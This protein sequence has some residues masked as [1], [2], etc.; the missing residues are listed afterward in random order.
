MR[1]RGLDLNLLVVLDALLAERNLSAA[2]RRINLSQP[3]MSAAVA[4]L[5]DFFGDELFS[6]NGRERILTS[7]AAALGPAVRDALLHIQRTIIS[8]D[9]FDPA[10]SDRRFRVTISDFATL[11]FFEKVVERVAREA[12]AVSFELLPVN[13]SPDELL[14]RGDVDF[15]V[16]PDLFTSSAHSSVALFDERLV[17]VGCPTN[18]QLRR[19]LTFERYLSMRHV[20]VRFGRSLMP[21]VEEWFLLEHGLKR[22]VEVAVQGFSMIPPMVSGT[23]RIATM[24]FRLVKY[25]EKTFPLQIVELPLPLPAFTEAVQWPALHNTDPASVWMREVMMQEAARMAVPL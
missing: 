2:A 8:S 10:R 11:V 9:P 6:M 3:A 14:G 24:P 20:S 16:L 12:P 1:F 19:Q 22:R 7:R 15:V 21:S 18:R 23:A 25:F 5:R 13:D 4:R 17:C